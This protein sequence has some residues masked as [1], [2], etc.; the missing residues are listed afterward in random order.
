[1]VVDINKSGIP[2]LVIHGIF[3]LFAGITLLLISSFD[4][5]YTTLSGSGAFFLTRNIY[6][7]LHQWQLELFKRLGRRVFKLSGII[8]NP[9][10]LSVWIL[11]ILLSL[12]L[13][14]SFNPDAIMN[15]REEVATRAERIYFTGYTLSTLGMGNFNPATL[16]FRY[17][18]VFFPFSALCIFPP[19]SLTLF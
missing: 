14:Y 6:K 2:N 11:L 7:L 5:F 4:F 10:I 12:F 8:I 17:S 1:L 19:P 18:L 3:Y 16:Y 13:I 15:G 9:G